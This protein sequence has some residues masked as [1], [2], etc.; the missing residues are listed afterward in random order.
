MPAHTSRP[1]GLIVF[2]LGIALLLVVFF[3]ARADLHSPLTGATADQALSL[4]QRIGLLFIMGYV[5]SSL[6]GR[7]CQMFQ[8]ASPLRE[9]IDPASRS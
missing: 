4:A 9:E 5:A 6:A 1:L 7:G 8:S 2:L 3:Q